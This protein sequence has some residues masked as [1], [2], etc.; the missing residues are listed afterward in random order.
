MTVLDFALFNDLHSKCFYLHL[1]SSLKTLQTQST[2]WVKRESEKAARL[3]TE[4]PASEDV[5]LS[6]C[7]LEAADGSA[8]YVTKCIDDYV[9]NRTI[10]SSADEENEPETDAESEFE[11]QEEQQE[12]Q[13]QQQ[14]QEQEQEQQQEQEQEQGQ[15]FAESEDGGDENDR[16]L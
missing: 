12:Y 15:D 5:D 8:S 7:F 1:F 9:N 13:E 4:A 2:T 3:L 16:E 10:E 11:E 14:Q 6:S